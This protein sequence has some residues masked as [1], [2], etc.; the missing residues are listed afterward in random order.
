VP[1]V[2]DFYLTAGDTVPP[3]TA[4][5]T[6]EAGAGLNLTGATVTFRMSPIAG[7]A[8]K[9]D[10]AATVVTPAAGAVSYAWQAADTD[11]PGYY[12]GRWRIVFS[13]GGVGSVPNDAPMLILIAAAV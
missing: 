12:L 10:A 13:G 9:V 11:T 1:L 8:L 7:G 5:L 4:T 6:D 3:I 2:A